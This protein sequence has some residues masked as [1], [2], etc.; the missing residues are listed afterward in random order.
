MKGLIL[1]VE[2]H[3]IGVLMTDQDLRVK[4]QSKSSEEEIK[5]SAVATLPVHLLF[6]SY[7]LESVK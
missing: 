3:Y 4:F 6:E 1:N 5:T 2:F 7:M